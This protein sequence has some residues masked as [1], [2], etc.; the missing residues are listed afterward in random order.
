MSQLDVSLSGRGLAPFVA[1]AGEL[2]RLQNGLERMLAGQGTLHWVIGQAGSGKTALLAEFARRAL[3]NQRNLL[4]VAGQCAPPAG[5]LSQPYL[6]FIE[7]LDMLAGEWEMLSWSAHLPAE[8]FARLQETLPLV[9]RTLVETAPAL[10][11]RLVGPARLLQRL[12]GMAGPPGSPLTEPAWM[13]H[14]RES[15]AFLRRSE[16]ILQQATSAAATAVSRLESREL[17]EQTTRLLSSLARRKPLVLL[18]DDIHW[19]DPDGAALLAHL[20]RS[21]AG[22][23]VLI[24][25]ASQPLAPE[26]AA[27]PGAHP[28]LSLRSA[29]PDPVSGFQIDLDQAGA[30]EFVRAFLACDPRLQ[31]QRLDQAFLAALA[32]HT[33]GNPLF[34]RQLLDDL[35]ACGGLQRDPQGTWVND[36]Q[37]AW[38]QMPGQVE[39]AV[40][41]RLR[42]LPAAWVDWLSTASIAGDRFAVEVIAGVHEIE[43]QELLAALRAARGELCGEGG[44][45]QPEGSA[46]AGTQRLSLY[47]FQHS[48]YQAGLYQ[49]LP[50]PERQRRHATVGFALEALCRQGSPGPAGLAYQLERHFEA[51]GLPL[52]AAACC[53]ETGKQAYSLGAMASAVAHYQHGL[54]LLAGLPP[55]RERD[56]LEIRLHL[57]LGAPFIITA[58]WDESRRQAA[59]QHALDRLRQAGPQVAAGEFFP[60]LCVQVDWLVNQGELQ[61]A[62][63]LGEQMLQLANAGKAQAKDA[64]LPGWR[65]MEAAAHWS[66]GY[67]RLFLGEL[68]AARQHLEQAVAACVSAAAAGDFI[69]EAN[70]A[71][72]P[73][74]GGDLEAVCRGFLAIAL[75]LLGY[76]DQAREQSRQAVSRAHSQRNPVILGAVLAAAGEVAT[77]CQDLPALP[78]LAAELHHLG[79]VRG[80]ESFLAYGL[81]ISGYAQTMQAEAAPVAA[82]AG[83]QRA[84]PAGPHLFTGNDQ[85][86]A[87]LVQ[88]EEGMALW[89]ASGARSARGRWLVHLARACLAAGQI[90]E[91]MDVVDGGL[92]GP[93]SRW[94]ITYRAELLRLRGELL[95]RSASPN[96]A[97]AERYFH[98]ALQRARQDA[99]LTLELSAALSLARLWRTSRPVEARQRLAEVYARFSEGWD[100][101]S[102]QE[103]RRLMATPT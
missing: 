99:A 98:H 17:F 26:P 47:R 25:V 67:P 85:A 90:A 46:W 73:W 102:L 92:E 93:G 20:G 31:P 50:Q 24:L 36:P 16:T 23:R 58:G 33:G 81:E 91:G 32:R 40:A 13:A 28:L 94:G 71:G 4:V 9:A 39:A 48:L 14:L 87:G 69:A 29:L 30:D 82:S 52:R 59:I 83:A 62:L 22:S 51:G 72:F 80:L 6:P 38:E 89:E 61:Q 18:L 11:E 86:Q 44:V 54:A 60:A 78:P 5:G 100:C 42:R 43:T 84:Y 70:P 68:L 41:G 57:A 19:I 55:T 74:A 49:Q 66:L 75:A 2:A 53:L 79:R 7:C 27:Q 88:I 3:A 77:L 103:A 34:T 97:A 15:E 1:R 64:A 12:P 56:R 95:L 101:P 65:L 76:L 21:L 10:L 96:P 37:L 8:V 45:L 63:Q 35:R